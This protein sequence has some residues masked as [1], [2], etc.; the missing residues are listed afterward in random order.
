MANIIPVVLDANG[1]AVDEGRR[2]R[3]ATKEQRRALRAMY[4]S[5]SIHGCRAPFEQCAIHHIRYW[6]NLGPSDLANMIPLCSKH[7]HCAHEGGWQ[8]HLHPHTRALT[9]TFPD[10][11]I[12]TT[13]PPHTRAG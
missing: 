2:T 7:H 12:Q 3:L 9:V 5:C 4:P 8:L 13:G 11:S 6:E 1:V 10:G